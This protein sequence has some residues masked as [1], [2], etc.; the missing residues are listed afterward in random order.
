MNKENWKIEL[1]KALAEEGIIDNQF[2]KFMEGKITKLP[3]KVEEFG[4]AV[5]PI[6][7][8]DGILTD[9]RMVVPI[10]YDEKSLCVNIHEYTHAYEVYFSLGK[11][12]IWNVE[13]SEQKAQDAEKR[14]LKRKNKR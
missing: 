2:H 9:I 13:E 1:N 7:N 10:I 12:Y 6:T 5:F 14:Y 8:K 4:W 11:K 3:L